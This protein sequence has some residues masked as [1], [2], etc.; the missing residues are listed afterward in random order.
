MADITEVT[1]GNS[2]G[3]NASCGTVISLYTSDDINRKYI[4]VGVAHD[5]FG[6][7]VLSIR[8]L[9]WRE[10]IRD[11]IGRLWCSIKSNRW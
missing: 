2:T 1:V 9:K 3:Y 4:V 7:T 10:K 8:G 11:Y 6:Q 5:G